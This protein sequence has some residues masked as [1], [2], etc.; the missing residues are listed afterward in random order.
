ML[1]H[2]TAERLREMKL[3]GMADGFLAQLQ[4]VESQGM[5]FEER[6]GLLVD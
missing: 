5:T 6:F 4:Q 2:E 1:N 3:V